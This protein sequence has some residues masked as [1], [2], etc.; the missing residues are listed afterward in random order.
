[1]IREEWSHLGRGVFRIVIC[2]FGER[3][4]RRPVGLFIIA[5]HA[6]E[7]FDDLIRDFS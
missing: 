4:E 5:E 7:L 6:K 3:K 1:M 2:E